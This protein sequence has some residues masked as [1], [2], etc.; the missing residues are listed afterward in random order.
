VDTHYSA[1][2]HALAWL[3][4][5]ICLH[6]HLN[7]PRPLCER[8]QRYLMPSLYI[9]AAVVA[10]LELSGVLPHATS[11]LA[12]PLALLA[13]LGPLSWR[14]VF[15]P[16]TA[17][18]HAASLMLVGVGLAGGPALVLWAMPTLLGAPV[19]KEMAL[20]AVMF[21]VPLLPFVY[22]YALYKHRLGALEPR[23]RRL[24]GLYSFLLLYGSA[25]AL[26]FSVA[27][28][29]LNPSGRLVFDLAVLTAFVVAAAPLYT[30]FQ[31]FVGRLAYGTR[32][33]PQ[34]VIATFSTRIASAR[35]LEALARLLAD[36]VAPSLLVRQSALLMLADGR[37]STVYACGVRPDKVP[38]TFERVE[39]LLAATGRYRPPVAAQGPLDWVRLAV[40][41]QASEKVVGLWLLGQRDPDD[42]Y[43]QSDVA[44]LSTLAGQA[45]VAFE[46]I[47]LYEQA[48]QS[49]GM[50]QAVL[51]AITESVLLID[52]QG[53]ILALNQT[54]AQ[55]LG[56]SVAQLVGSRLHDLPADVLP[57]PLLEARM[58]HVDEVVR[59]G[60]PVRFEDEREG[61]RFDHSLYPVLDA[62]G[63]TVYIVI[64]AQDIT[65][66]KRAEQRAAHAERLAALGRL[67][68]ALAHEINN[69]LQ[70]IQ[71]N[72][73]LVT[74]FD[75]PPEERQERLALM[76][77]ELERLT[78]LTARLLRLARPAADTRYAVSVSQLVQRA[79]ALVG[80]Q[81]HKARIQVTT[82]LPAD[83]PMIFAAAD[84]IVQVLL[85]LFLN[86]IEAMPD[87]GHLHVTS[88]AEGDM[89]ALTLTNDG[90][91]IPP[92]HL[93]HL[94]EP[95]FTTKPGGTGLGLSLSHSIVEQHGGTI[96]VNN[97][98]SGRGVAFTITLPSAS[99]PRQ[100]EA[101]A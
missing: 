51:N 76:R 96:Y 10:L 19:P 14:V 100:P 18:R 81:L 1:N 37:C 88:R 72:L 32:H 89:V 66:R 11:G 5:P 47:R 78:D 93:G 71:S 99:C 55:R 33:D 44:L 28:R 26:V 30:R 15:R 20:C 46:N 56:G 62:Q 67:G 82:E 73:E 23:A 87:G 8:G 24:L 48:R 3:L 17:E 91:P 36:E 79:L 21:S 64:F 59:S 95:F 65:E 50:T 86:A 57:R 43:P 80:S 101:D 42:Y 77:R 29:W 98:E 9:V 22:A 35:S 60:K 27:G 45:A 49:E 63:N 2:L 70:G 83:G 38:D 31:R 68:A 52:P 4:V 90:P 75:L 54:A 13:S 34:E 74:G 69:P 97:L 6:L 40:A 39:P 92:E 94:F 25:F 61:R 16:S 84:Q 85:N 41:L 58:A 7:V 12:L 53:T